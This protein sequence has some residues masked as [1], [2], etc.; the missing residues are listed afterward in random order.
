MASVND[1]ESRIQNLLNTRYR[2]VPSLISNNTDLN[3]VVNCG[4]YYS[5]SSSYTIENSPLDVS[6]FELTVTGISPDRTSYTTQLIKDH[7][8]NN[9]YVRTQTN[10][11]EPWSWTSWQKIWLQGDRI[12]NAVW[13]DYAEYF[14]KGEETEP[15]DIIALDSNSDKEQ[16]IKADC[17]SRRV[18]GVHSDSYGH[19]LGG[20][21]VEDYN[22]FFEENDKKYI[23]VGLNGRVYVKIKGPVKIGDYIVPSE[24]KGIGRAL[25]DGE[26]S[27]N[28]IGYVVE[29]DNLTEERR[30]KIFIALGG[31]K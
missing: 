2:I 4:F 5:P 30:V 28:I 6:A 14:P 18:I 3:N 23:P 20:D 13:N 17:N 15:G 27:K 19:I 24:E 16:Y 21:K 8:T 7:S 10:W 29:P 1:H 31:G 9:Y 22:K 25:K 26:K 12:T 11:Q